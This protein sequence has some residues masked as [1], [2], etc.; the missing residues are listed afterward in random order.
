MR[1]ALCKNLDDGGAIV[2]EDVVKPQ[3]G[4]GEVL[5]RVEAA[6]LNFFDNLIIRGKYQYRPDLPFSPCAEIAGI[7]EGL[8][9]GVTKFDVGQR[10]ISYL[11][12][13]GAREYVSVREELLTLLPDE[14]SFEAGCGIPVTYGTGYYG[15][16]DRG[17]LKGGETLAVLGAAGGAGLAAVELGKQM[18]ARVIAV[19]SSDEKLA[20][21]REHGADEI[22]NYKT[23]DL[24][25]A[26]KEVTGGKG[27][28]VVYDCVGGVH[29]EA[30]LRA[31]AWEGRLLIIGFAAGDIP[32]LPANLMLLKGCDV[33]GVFW[34]SMLER[35]P[36]LQAENSRQ[37]L[38]WCASGAMVPHIHGTYPLSQIGEGLEVLARRE[39]KGKVVIL[40]QI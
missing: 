7:V 27:V 12:W 28:D 34:G 4:K 21:C 13:G 38:E 15:L 33:V 19:A 11:G 10:V 3:A 30:A 29:T 8:G 17:H 25:D 31:M 20:V 23:A 5:V 35:T 6:A 9:E 22:I 16:K 37:I 39:A 40:P 36:E 1:A 24:K 2:I 26:L 32:K 18:G 14:V